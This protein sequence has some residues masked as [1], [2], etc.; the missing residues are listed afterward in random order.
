M[1]VV[2]RK[3]YKVI[4]CYTYDTI[5]AS[6]YLADLINDCF[7]RLV[8]LY[9]AK[10]L[11]SAHIKIV[12]IVCQLACVGTMKAVAMQTMG[13]LSVILMFAF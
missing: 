2:F 13:P 10:H 1:K 8:W 9:W 12:S 5:V 7:P 11:C 6:P 3:F 4:K